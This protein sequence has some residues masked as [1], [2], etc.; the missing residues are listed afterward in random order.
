MALACVLS[1]EIRRAYLAGNMQSWGSQFV[2]MIIHP[3]PENDVTGLVKGG[4]LR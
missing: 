3:S 2:A 4:F 1:L